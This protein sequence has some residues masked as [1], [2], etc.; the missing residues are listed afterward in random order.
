LRR[1][2]HVPAPAAPAGATLGRPRGEPRR[3]ARGRMAPRPNSSRR[4]GASGRHGAPAAAAAPSC[5]TSAGRIA[6]RPRTIAFAARRRLGMPAVCGFPP[7]SR[8][9]SSSLEE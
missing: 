7:R 8:R 4:A 5:N 6:G 9:A 3:S 2:R 1:A